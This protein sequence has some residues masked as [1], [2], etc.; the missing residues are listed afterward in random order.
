MTLIELARGVPAAE[1]LPVDDVATAVSRAYAAAPHALLSYGTG[2]G[3]MPLRERLADLHGV[4]AHNVVVT[5]GSLQAFALLLELLRET[6]SGT[7]A[8]PCIGV[9]SPTYDRPLILAQ[10]AGAETVGIALQSDGTGIDLDHLRTTLSERRVD[11]L[12]RSRIRQ[13][14]C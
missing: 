2:G 7:G 14:R 12:Q 11:L 8:V 10:R 3:W 6:Y 1:M 5:P 4:Q 9:E 13:G